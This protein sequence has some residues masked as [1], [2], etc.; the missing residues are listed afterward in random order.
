MKCIGEDIGRV[1]INAP[2]QE[3]PDQVLIT[4]EIS[5]VFGHKAIGIET[6]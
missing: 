2:Y 1:A 5:V 3:M 4:G 6:L